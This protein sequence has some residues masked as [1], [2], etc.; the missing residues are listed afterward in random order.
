MVALATQH[1]P[2]FMAA[3]MVSAAVIGVMMS[4]VS[5]AVLTLFVCCH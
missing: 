1:A 4:V 2:T 5:S 3:W